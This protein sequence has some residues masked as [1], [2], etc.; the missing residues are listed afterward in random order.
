MNT[1]EPFYK[2][3]EATRFLAPFSARVQNVMGPELEFC[4]IPVYLVTFNI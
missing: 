3:L 1:V 4:N 2:T